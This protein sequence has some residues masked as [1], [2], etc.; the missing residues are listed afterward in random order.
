MTAS[1][2]VTTSVDQRLNLWSYDSREAMLKLTTSFTHDVADVASMEMLRN[3]LAK[4][5]HKILFP[6]PTS[7]KE[8]FW[9]CILN[10][11]TL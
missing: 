10:T 8:G 11:G 1:L 6:D 3:R 7:C 2:L 4:S 5:T 9:Y